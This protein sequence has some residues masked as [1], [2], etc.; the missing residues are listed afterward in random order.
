MA[1]IDGQTICLRFN[2]Y[3]RDQGEPAKPG[4]LTAALR[5][6]EARMGNHRHFLKVSKALPAYAQAVYRSLEIGR[7]WREILQ[8]MK[9][10]RPNRPAQRHAAGDLAA[11]GLACRRET[12]LQNKPNVA[13]GQ[14]KQRCCSF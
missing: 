14:T 10:K 9:A 11:V 8:P 5:L 12:F 4:F 1:K 3:S 7:A 6:R 13:T 2:G